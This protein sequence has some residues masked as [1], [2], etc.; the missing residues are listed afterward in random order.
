MSHNVLEVVKRGREIVA[1]VVNMRV[2]D[3]G[4]LFAFVTM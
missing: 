3:R 4:P 1:R 2:R